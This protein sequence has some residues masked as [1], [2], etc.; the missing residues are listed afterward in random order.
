MAQH[1]DGGAYNITRFDYGATVEVYF[2]PIA[3]FLDKHPFE[4][5]FLSLSNEMKQFLSL[6]KTLNERVN[7]LI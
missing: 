3:T 2:K 7:R 5:V 6:L 4:V 1:G